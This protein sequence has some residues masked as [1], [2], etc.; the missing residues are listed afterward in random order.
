[1]TRQQKQSTFAHTLK[2]WDTDMRNAIKQLQEA[3]E[4]EM[5]ATY[6]HQYDKAK[7]AC[8]AHLEDI[9]DQ[10]NAILYEAKM[11]LDIYE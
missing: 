3:E 5:T 2:G 9:I 4:A 8:R 7:K 10:A 1:M 6:C 11:A